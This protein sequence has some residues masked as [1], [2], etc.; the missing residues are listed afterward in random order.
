M[1]LDAMGYALTK[2]GA[3]L[4]RRE[5]TL[6]PSEGDVIVEV[7]GCGVCHTD[8]S[9]ALDGVP[10]RQPLPLILGHEISGR[11]VAAGENAE[12]WLGRNVLNPR[13][14]SLRYL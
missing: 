3:P 11:V 12:S 9:F 13:G 10:T 8:V 6:Q 5:F 7:A 2:V 14:D 4:Q 1:H